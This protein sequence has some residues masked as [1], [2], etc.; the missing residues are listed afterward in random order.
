MEPRVIRAQFHYKGHTIYVDRV[1][2]WVCNRCGEKYFDAPVY[3]QLEAIARHR[4]RITKTVS[5]PLA[6]YEKAL[7]EVPLR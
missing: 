2:A 3:K 6:D 7:A 4:R 1:P 5:F